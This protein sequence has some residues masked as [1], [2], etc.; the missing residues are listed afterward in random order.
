MICGCNHLV[1]AN[2]RSRFPFSA[3]QRPYLFLLWSPGRNPAQ[4]SGSAADK[5]MAHSASWK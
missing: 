4:Q 3:N 1:A 5:R 2:R